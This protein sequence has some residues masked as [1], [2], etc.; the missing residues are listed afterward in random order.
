MMG[1]GEVFHSDDD[2]DDDDE[3]VRRRPTMAE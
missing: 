2:D 1:S 3:N